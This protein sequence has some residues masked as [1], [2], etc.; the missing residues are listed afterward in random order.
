MKTYYSSSLWYKGRGLWGLPQRVNWYFEHRSAKC[1]IPVVYRFQKGIV[2]DIITF[3]EEAKLREFFEKYEAE[4][5]RLT[6]LQQRCIEQEHPY[7][8]MAIK[9]IC[10]NGKKIEGNYSSSSAVSIPWAGKDDTLTL[11]GKAYASIIKNRTSFG[12]QRFC[13]PYPETNSKVQKLLRFFSFI[14]I[15]S[16][17]LSTHPVKWFFPL[18]IHFEIRDQESQKKVRFIHPK[19]GITHTLYFQNTRSVEMPMGTD[20]NR[21]FYIMQAMYEI[22]PKLP[23]GDSLQFS[24]SMQ[25]IEPSKNQFSPT[26]ASAIGIIGG[27]SGPTA[28]FTAGKNK[29]EAV[30]H[31]SHGLPLHCCFSVPGFHREDASNFVLEGIN[32]KVYDSKE[33]DFS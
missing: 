6:P 15:K 22:E 18:D 19:T 12:C 20:E 24:S 14:R 26:A 2:F 23:Q 32:T 1:C 25:Y 8:S 27:A 4:E 21:N 5:K 33:Y 7:Q 17:K 13:V 9:E 30:N 3:L 31:G 28:V 11:V 10:I 16:L 29:E